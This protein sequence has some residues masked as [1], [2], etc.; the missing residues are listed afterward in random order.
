MVLTMLKIHFIHPSLIKYQKL[1]DLF[2]TPPPEIPKCEKIIKACKK[3]ITDTNFHQNCMKIKLDLSLTM[4]K[5]EFEYGDQG[6]T[7]GDRYFFLR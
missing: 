2:V 3:K 6:I 1:K 5:N 4:G 7:F